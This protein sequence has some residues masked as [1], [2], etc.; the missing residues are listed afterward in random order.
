MACTDSPATSD[1]ERQLSS[2]LPLYGHRNWIVVTD[3]AYPAQSN[4]GIQTIAANADQVEVLQ[5]V[6]AA[7]AGC[8]HIKPSVYVDQELDYVAEQ[9]APGVTQYREQLSSLLRDSNL[10]QLPHED[11]IAKLDQAAKMFQVLIIKST[12]T[13]PYTSVF[14]ELG[15]GYWSD[16]G[17]RRLRGALASGTLPACR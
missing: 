11:I 2:C 10:S 6:L 7:V 15:C 17:E 3:A 1:W 8:S 9:D 5:K 13:I 14:L 4:P 12:M 16:E